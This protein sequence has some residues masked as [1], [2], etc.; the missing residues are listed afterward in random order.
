MKN[1]FLQELYTK[2]SGEAIPR[3]FHKKS[4][5][6]INSTKFTLKRYKVCFYCMSKPSS[7]KIY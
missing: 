2:C 6:S 1:F 5:F 4:E 3:T 7:T